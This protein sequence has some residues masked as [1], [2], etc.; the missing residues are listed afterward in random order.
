VKFADDWWWPESET[1]M[2]AWVADPRN[3][4]ML[5]G[6]PAYQGKK[7]SAALALCKRFRMAIDVGAH[8]GT[9]A[10][11]LAAEFKDVR[12]FEPILEHR[13]CLGLNLE[14]ANVIV[15]PL[16]LGDRSGMVTMRTGPSS[17]GD[18]YVDPARQ[19]DGEIRMETLDSFGFDDVDFIKIDCEGFEE[20]VLRGARSTLLRCLPVVCVEQKRDF[21]TKYGM[22]PRGGV[23]FLQSLGYTVAVEISGDYIMT[24]G[25]R[26]P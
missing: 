23:Q 9:W 1:H 25:P 10:Y 15:Y 21:A 11:N 22:Q 26:Q 8:I 4:V 3:R 19:T 5:N 16:A 17:T 24:P 13:Q 18:T 12:C 7:Q 2:N 6:R 14:A 20:R